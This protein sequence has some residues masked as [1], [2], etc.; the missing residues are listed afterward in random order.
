MHRY[1]VDFSE[2]LDS[3]FKDILKQLTPDRSHV[4]L[5]DSINTL[6][7]TFCNYYSKTLSIKK[8]MKNYEKIRRLLKH[9][10][11]P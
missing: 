2:T 1:F 6:V 8:D 9:D 10:L 7:H 4:H 11:S 5:Y 3:E